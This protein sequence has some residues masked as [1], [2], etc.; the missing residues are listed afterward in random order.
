MKKKAFSK[1][2]REHTPEILTGIGIAGMIT[3]TILAVKA[4]PK[5][6]DI[7]EEIKE[8]TPKENKKEYGKAIVTKVAPVYIPSALLCSVSIACLVGASSVNYKRNAALATA[9]TISKTAL[10]EYQAKVVET[11][12]EK[13]ERDIRDEVAKDKVQKNPVSNTEVYITSKGDTLFYDSVSGRYFLSDIDKVRKIENELNRRLLSEMD[14][15]L[16]ELY[17]ELGLMQTKVGNDLGFNI[18]NGLIEFTYSAQLADDGRP[19]ICLG[20]T[21]EPRYSYH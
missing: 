17:F 5:A 6:L 9:Y 8:T 2:I 19:C 13:K 20:Y 16:N 14:I 21:V 10:E 11:I 15:S 3:T 18:D 1:I 7:L 12:G 4:T